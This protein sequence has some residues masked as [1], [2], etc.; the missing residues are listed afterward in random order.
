MLGWT[1]NQA[2]WGATL[3][4]RDSAVRPGKLAPLGSAGDSPRSPAAAPTAARK[5][6][7]GTR[8]LWTHGAVQGPVAAPPLLCFC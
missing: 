8:A 7:Q 1:R 5:W 2:N 3:R 6:A 4:C